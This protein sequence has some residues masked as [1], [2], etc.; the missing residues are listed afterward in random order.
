[1]PDD[2]LTTVDALAAQ[3]FGTTD[4]EPSSTGTETDPTGASATASDPTPAGSSPNTGANDAGGSA[5]DKTI[6]ELIAKRKAEHPEL[7]D[8]VDAI[9][10]EL[11]GGYTKKFQEVADQRKQFEGID[12]NDLAFIRHFNTLQT[13]QE[14]EA[15]F[16]YQQ[17]LARSQQPNQEPAA[18]PYADLE[19][20]LPAPVIERLRQYDALFEQQKKTEERQ[21]E[22]QTRTEVDRQF[23]T[24]QSEVGEIGVDD[25]N[26][27]LQFLNARGLGV[28]DISLAYNH[29]F[30]DKLKQRWIEQGHQTRQLKEGATPPPASTTVRTGSAPAEI[31]TRAA[32]NALLGR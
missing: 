19:Y 30:Q 29:L 11:Q 26:K 18:D 27:V 16:A 1:M 24:L 20:E 4:N 17:Q 10:R 6:Q 23:T 3:M 12:P 22:A 21:Q 32:L 2:I 28:Q 7:A 9:Y 25:R 13:P 8:A 5:E 14:R 15:F 31:D